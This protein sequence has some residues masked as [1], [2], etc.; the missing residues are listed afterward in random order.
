MEIERLKQEITNSVME[1]ILKSMTPSIKKSGV[2]RPISKTT[3]FSAFDEEEKDVI[4]EDDIKLNRKL[5]KS[6]TEKGFIKRS[7][8]KRISNGDLKSLKFTGE[9]SNKNQ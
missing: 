9:E 5:Q 4:K 6:C 8:P 2:K 3:A 7:F 1:K